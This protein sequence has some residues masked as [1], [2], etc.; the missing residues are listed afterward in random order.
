MYKLYNNDNIIN[1]TYHTSTIFFY[2]YFYFYEAV[3]R[4]EWRV[5]NTHVGT[6]NSI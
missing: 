6:T 4:S 5:G 1:S 3:F 2:F